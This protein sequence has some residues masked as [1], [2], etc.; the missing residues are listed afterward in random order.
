MQRLIG[1]LNVF[2]SVKCELVNIVH[3]MTYTQPSLEGSRGLPQQSGNVK[4]LTPGAPIS[5]TQGLEA[6]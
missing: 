2:V 4:I 6:I 5:T 3:P 1:P